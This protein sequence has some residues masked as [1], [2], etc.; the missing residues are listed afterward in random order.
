MC[1][2]QHTI[3]FR[4]LCLQAAWLTTTVLSHIKAIAKSPLSVFKIGQYFHNAD[5]T[6]SAIARVAK[7]SRAEM[8]ELLDHSID[9]G[10]QEE[11][12]ILISITEGNSLGQVSCRLLIKTLTHI[13][14]SLWLIDFVELHLL[15]SKCYLASICYQQS[16]AREVRSEHAHPKLGQRTIGNDDQAL[17]V[18]S[19]IV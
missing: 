3:R 8:E 12:H 16:K 1:I 2:I 13:P 19:L 5:M 14:A 10:L 9:N 15:H 6:D 7:R 4:E 18:L 17:C 11:R